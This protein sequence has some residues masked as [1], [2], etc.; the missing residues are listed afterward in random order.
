MD[1]KTTRIG[2]VGLGAMGGPIARRLHE[3]GSAPRVYDANPHVRVQ[4]ADEG[5]AVADSLLE[6]AGACD[7]VICMLPHPDILA[8]L[9][10]GEGGLGELLA[11]GA[12]LIDMATD[13]PTVVRRIHHAVAEREIAVVDAPVGRGPRAAES[14]ELLI[15]LGGDPEHRARAERVLA[16]VGS[17]FFH[18]GGLGTGQALKIANNFV[19]SANIAVLAE[20]LALAEAA[21]V[22]LSMLASV[23]SK[24]AANSFQL[25][26]GVIGKALKGDYSPIM[27]L[28]LTKKDMTLAM[29]LVDDLGVVAPCGGATRDWFDQASE[30]GMGGLDQT[31]LVALTAPSLRGSPT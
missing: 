12:L 15:F 24:T 17:E 8:E 23:M 22:D 25:N 28:D 2:V 3:S 4:F 5:I 18:C 21:E 26:N 7:V 14:G 27:R 29:M 20:A 9:I 6:L 10:L 31:A 1:S 16:P 30:K 11:P 19:Q 13:G